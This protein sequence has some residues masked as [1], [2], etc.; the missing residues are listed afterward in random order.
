MAAAAAA[1]R[2]V[3]ERARWR[4][5]SIVKFYENDPT[6]VIHFLT[7][8]SISRAIESF[9]KVLNIRSKDDTCRQVVVDFQKIKKTLENYRKTGEKERELFLK[10]SSSPPVKFI[11]FCFLETPSTRTLDRARGSAILKNLV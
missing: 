11:L 8:M 6:V 10:P 2:K 1:A 5:Q 4:A 3:R 9:L 7:P